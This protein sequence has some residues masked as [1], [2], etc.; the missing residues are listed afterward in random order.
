[1]CFVSIFKDFFLSICFFFLGFRFAC[2]KFQLSIDLFFIFS[3]KL[4]VLVA[5]LCSSI[6]VKLDSFVHVT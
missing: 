3:S 1:M 2:F 6:V 4:G 5:Q